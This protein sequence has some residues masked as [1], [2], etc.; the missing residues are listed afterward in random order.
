MSWIKLSEAGVQQLSSL[1]VRTRPVFSGDDQASYETDVTSWSILRKGWNGPSNSAR[2]SWTA[3]GR[4]ENSSFFI[5]DDHLSAVL[6]SSIYNCNIIIYIYFFSFW[7]AFSQCA[8]FSLNSNSIRLQQISFSLWYH[9][10]SL[11]ITLVFSGHRPHILQIGVS[12]WK[13]IAN[14]SI[15]W[16][17]CYGMHRSCGPACSSISSVLVSHPLGQVGLRREFLHS[18]SNLWRRGLWRRCLLPLLVGIR[19]QILL[20]QTFVSSEE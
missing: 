10:K 1:Y 4:S 15:D 11:F 17:R 20:V 2:P 7:P 16:L 9:L 3:T 19:F 6:D 5:I 8:V 13:I 12:R 14:H 18:G